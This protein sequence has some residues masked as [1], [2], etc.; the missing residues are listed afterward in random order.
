MLLLLVIDIDPRCRHSLSSSSLI[1]VVGD[2]YRH[3]HRS[4]LSALIIA[5]D[6]CRRHSLSSDPHRW[7]SALSSSPQILVVGT[8]DRHRSCCRH[9]LSCC[10]C[11]SWLS[12]LVIS[13]RFRNSL[14]C[15]S[16]LVTLTLLVVS[17]LA[18]VIESKGVWRRQREGTR[19]TESIEIKW[20]C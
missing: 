14:F 2:R 3:C 6:P 19:I 20:N 5:I 11:C 1:L 9:L 10:R 13:C 8:R 15:G 16:L 4:S 17:L 12:S 7:H 18:L